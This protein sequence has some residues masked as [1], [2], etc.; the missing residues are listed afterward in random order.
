MA[1]LSNHSL[2]PE[3]A[4][5]AIWYQILVERF[6][7]G[8]SANDPTRTSIEGATVDKVPED[9]QIT[10]W[11][12]N[13]YESEEW[14]KKMPVDFYRAVQLRR[15]GGDFQ[16]VLD[17]LPY[18]K[19]LGITAIYFNP[20]NQAPSLHKYDASF[21][22][23]VDPHFGPD[24]EGD[25][26]A[27]REENPADPDTW[28]WTKADQM[29]IRLVQACHDAGIKVVVDFSWNHTGHTFWAFEDIKKKG[30]KSPYVSWYEGVS[31]TRKNGKE[32]FTYKSWNNVTTLPEF[33]KNWVTAEND[34]G[35]EGNLDEELKKHIFDVCRRWI[36]PRIHGQDADGI[37]GLRLD[38]ADLLPHSF[39]KELRQ[40]VRELK[41]DFFLTGEI[42]WEDWPDKLMD[43]RPWL[44]G[45]TF[46]SVMHYHWFQCARAYF[47]DSADN[48]NIEEFIGRMQLLYHDVRVE[49]CQVFMNLV[50]SHDSPRMLTAV[51]NKNKYKYLCK[52]Q[53]DP[54]YRTEYPDLI[55]YTRA[56]LL[57]IH[58]FTF[59]GTPHIWNGDE[60]GMVG[61]DDPDNR[62]P[63]VWPDIW[64][65]YETASGYSDYSYKNRP[66]FNAFLHT[67]YKS[68]IRL[69]KK[70]SCLQQ[71][72]CVFMTDHVPDNK[73]LIYR[74]TYN[75]EVLVVII[76]NN[77]NERNI[78]LEYKHGKPVFQY[79]VT[80]SYCDVLPS[81]SAIIKRMDS[82]TPA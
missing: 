39:W 31:R 2:P 20:L 38:V 10:P 37:D 56:C 50:A 82:N 36:K 12:H 54:K 9:W 61:A 55:T 60:M 62:K 5:R 74:R 75:E 48:I 71:G 49:N 22:H 24:P 72:N 41:P 79:N 23:H 58:Q 46:D 70:Y 18:L 65:E 73:L 16:G 47:G 28:I 27:L 76:N 63:L 42:W 21:Y 78:P 53:E 15:Y 25:K 26:A 1:A 13:W 81:Y 52:P 80:D 66:V 51:Y 19:Q 17:K 6:R 3:W 40:F 59:L 45:D 29:F 43:P 64:F 7:S 77:D 33:R 68:L 14:A 69:R 30:E 35:K 8:D 11:G 67:F 34:L 44:Q 57:L 4:Y 32:Y